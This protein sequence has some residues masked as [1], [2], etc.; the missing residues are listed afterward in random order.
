MADMTRSPTFFVP[1]DRARHVLEDFQRREQNLAEEYQKY[2]P[3]CMN[4][5]A[6]QKTHP[7]K[8]RMG[9]KDADAT[10]TSPVL[11]GVADG[12]SQVEDFG[13]DASELPH[14]LL[15]VCEELAMQCL[16]PGVP[17]APQDAYRGPIPLL[18]DAFEAT[19]CLGS[20]TIVLA[21]LDNSTQIH[22]KNHPMVAV[23]TIGDCELLLLRRL[24][25]Q[26]GA[27]QA[28]FHTEMQRI[29]GHCQQPLQ[30]ARVDHRID[31][32]FQESITIEVIERGSAVHCISA[33]EGDI[34]VMGSDGVFDNLFLDEIVETCNSM[35]P[36]R[37][38]K[39]QPTNEALLALIAQRIVNQCHAKTQRGKNGQMPDTPI[40]RGGK[41]DD[42]SIVV[43][44]VVAWTE[45][46]KSHYASRNT[47][48]GWDLLMCGSSVNC[49]ADKDE[50]RYEYEDEM[51]PAYHRPAH[52]KPRRAPATA[53]DDEDDDD[54][55][56]SVS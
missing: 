23:I 5:R 53:D 27:L 18:R 7:S 55:R 42:T 48:W 13:I 24:N 4:A 1:A 9:H 19:E 37:S 40:G 52:R 15:R 49:S 32:D 30:L 25:R 31:P 11:I 14:E 47:G 28:V 43:A 46:H 36:P 51:M 12:V 17:V 38:G 10:L 6:Y 22:G 34:L 29:D 20:T 16:I 54:L 35:M 26:S 2:K 50:S 41:M 56:C 3:L 45:D 39:F 8:L 33:Y 44:E 21:I